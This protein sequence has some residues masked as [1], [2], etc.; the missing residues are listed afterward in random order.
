M[1]C[2]RSAAPRRRLAAAGLLLTLALAG[3]GRSA[4]ERQAIAMTGGEP[5]R[6]RDAIRRYG[7]ASCHT[8]PGVDGAR[9][10]VGPSLAGIAD[11]VYLAGRLANTPANLIRWT[12]TP[13]EIEPGN[14]MPDLGVT[15]R[16]GRDIAAYL[17]T[18]RQ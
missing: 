1:G 14:A 8:V 3:C 4:D 11:R 5:S 10:Q 16:D 13:Q 9:G 18:L 2:E 17:Y 7:C 15:E 12:R 6:G